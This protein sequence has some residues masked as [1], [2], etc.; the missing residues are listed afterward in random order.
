MTRRRS[1][2]AL[3]VFIKYPEEGQVKTRLALEAGNEKALK[4][5]KTLL[6]YTCAVVEALNEIDV[7][8]YI[9]ELPA[10][11]EFL[12]RKISDFGI[13]LSGDLG[14]KMQS[15][16]SDEIHNYDHAIIIGSDCPEISADL[17][18]LARSKLTTFDLVIGPSNDGGY[19]LLGLNVVYNYLF[20]NIQWSSDSV[21]LVTIKRSLSMGLRVF[22]L[23]PLDDVDY[24]KDWIKYKAVLEDYSSFMGM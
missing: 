12:G 24:M 16:L 20:E 19:Y 23:P 15:A 21:A 3:I 11:E 1:N 4:I 17:I 7:K 6:G 9:N 2:T 18:Q 22:L 5:Y 8:F 14:Y 10:K 13:Q